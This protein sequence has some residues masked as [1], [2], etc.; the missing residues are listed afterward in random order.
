MSETARD[1]SQ[2]YWRPANLPTVRA[3]RPILAESLCP[4]CGVEYAIG[5]HYCYECG[6]ERNG[7][8][9]ALRRK[10]LAD[11]IDTE[12]IRER[13]GLSAT[14]LVLFVAGITCL[15]IAAAMGLIDRTE[16]QLDPEVLQ[17]W[18][19]EWLLGAIAALLAGVLLKKKTT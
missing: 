9:G 4:K 13:L 8:S 15:V 18:R 11:S 6:R 3:A 14:C 12:I 5:A 10:R 7:R 19:I 2:E 17:F 16:A 1:L